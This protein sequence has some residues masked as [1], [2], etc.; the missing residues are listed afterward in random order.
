MK[1]ITDR[2]NQTEKNVSGTGNRL[3]NYYIQITIKKEKQS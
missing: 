1:S 2:L 3:R